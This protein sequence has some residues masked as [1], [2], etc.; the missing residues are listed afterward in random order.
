MELDILNLLLVLG[1]AWIAG[2]VVQRLGYPSVLGELGAGIVLGPPL[3][4][5]LSVGDPLMVIADLG[6]LLMMVYIGMEIDLRDLGRASTGGLLAAIGG[7]F[8]PFGLGYAVTIAFG[9]DVIAALFIGMAVGVTSLATKSRILVDLGLLDTR[10]A[11]VMMAGALISDT[12]SLIV[13][14][15]ILSVVTIGT[16]TV[17]GMGTIALQIA[18][19]FF[20]AWLL[21][22]HVVPHVF[23]WVSRRG[24]DGRTFNLTL[25]LLVALLFA[26]LAELA[27]LHGILGAFLAGLFLREGIRVRRL[28]HDISGVVKDV[29]LGFLAPVF[30]VTAGFEVSFDVFR[31]DL[32]FLFTVMVVAIVGKIVG[33]ALFYLPSGHGWREGITVGFGMNGRGAVEIIIAGVGLQAGIIDQSIFSILVFM[34]IF[35]TASVPVTLK[36]GVDWLRRNDQLVRADPS[37][38]PALIV[39]AGAL[40]REIAHHLAP[41]RPVRLIDLSPDKV[42]LALEKGLTA[43]QG[44]ALDAD[45]LARAGVEDC[46]TVVAI[47]P[48]PAVNVLVAQ[49]ARSVFLVANVRAMMRPDSD[50]GL[51]DVLRSLGAAP[52]FG[53]PI[54]YARWEEVAALAERSELVEMPAAAA[55]ARLAEEGL[56]SLSGLLP[57]FVRRSGVLRLFAAAEEIADTDEVLF[58]ADPEVYRA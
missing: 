12:L 7:F 17:F 46:G 23:A 8:V 43:H 32:A 27:G 14:A 57:L 36:W 21:G 44:D 6:V 56:G 29:S 3:L 11:H 52:L 30:F 31:D 10:I 48:N 13:F 51:F 42:A 54:D 26:E 15:G 39:G 25:T 45:A 53:V 24:F 33:T 50:A 20:A 22:T 9:G 58:L 37:T 4:G 40:G 35:T 18:L 38:K 41:Y 28:S 2:T 34:A 55:R 16:L 1:V 19:F 5:W 49:R 47:T